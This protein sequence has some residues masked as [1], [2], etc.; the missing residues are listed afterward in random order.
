MKRLVP[1]LITAM[2]VC[3][4]LVSSTSASTCI[5]EPASGNPDP[6]SSLASSTE[7]IDAIGGAE[8]VMSEMSL[9]TRFWTYCVS[10]GIGLTT[11]PLGF[12]LLIH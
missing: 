11:H 12:T 1:K 3:G 4:V 10:L 5:I 9:E 8:G 2:L 6:C 7:S